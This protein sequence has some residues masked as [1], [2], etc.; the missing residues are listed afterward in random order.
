MA[1]CETREDILTSNEGK[2]YTRMLNEQL[3]QPG[4]P[5]ERIFS[6]SEVLQR[7]LKV[8]ESV[9]TTRM[10]GAKY[11]SDVMTALRIMKD[12]PKKKASVEDVIAF[13]DAQSYGLA[14]KLRR[15]TDNEF[16]AVLGMSAFD[17]FIAANNGN[18]PHD[19]YSYPE[20]N[21]RGNSPDSPAIIS[22]DKDFL[23]FMHIIGEFKATAPQNIRPAWQ[24]GQVGITRQ[25]Y[26]QYVDM[27]QK[28]SRFFSENREKYIAELTDIVSG[29]HYFYQEGHD[30]NYFNGIKPMISLS[31]EKTGKIRFTVGGSSKTFFEFEPDGD[32]QVLI[33]GA[34]IISVAEV[35][36]M[37]GRKDVQFHLNDNNPF[38]SGVLRKLAGLHNAQNID[39]VDGGMEEIEL[40]DAS[41]DLIVLSLI[42]KAG[43]E[44]VKA[45]AARAMDMLK[46]KGS[47]LIYNM[48]KRSDPEDLS[49]DDLLRI[50]EHTGFTVKRHETIKSRLL[51][52][53][54]TYPGITK[55]LLQLN[56]EG[57]FEKK[58]IMQNLIPG[59]HA[60]S[61]VELQKDLQ[62]GGPDSD[63]SGEHKRRGK[64]LPSYQRRS[65]RSRR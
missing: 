30:R 29:V 3:G 45:F 24:M 58:R 22:R 52:D 49:T 42:H 62:P 23:M 12:E 15:D 55:N 59:T 20:V 56:A 32:F 46:D 53:H 65:K 33:P 36:A 44:K 61:I 39:T 2:N 40:P 54:V 37:M 8:M 1:K 6:N 64:M 19:F 9:D 47:V 26:T 31:P 34:G 21:F 10:L 13:N 57:L 4:L 28:A 38:V 41:Q 7:A 50:F 60:F 48:D 27:L 5:L 18:C 17:M 25:F 16:P 35:P 43:A 63:Q 51:A 14:Q 11:H